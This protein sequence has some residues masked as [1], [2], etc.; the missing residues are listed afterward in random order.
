[1]GSAFVQRTWQAVGTHSFL[2]VCLL[3]A[4]GLERA[5]DE[6]VADG[7]TH[8]PGGIQSYIAG[9]DPQNGRNPNLADRPERGNRQVGR[10]KRRM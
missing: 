5:V 4:E 8:P 9:S 1:M 10:Q 3:S 6:L 2:D 7:Q